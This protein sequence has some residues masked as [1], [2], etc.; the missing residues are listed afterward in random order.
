MLK[1]KYSKYMVIAIVALVAIIVWRLSSSY[2]SVN[3]GYTGKNI[4][5]GD[6]W[7]VNITKVGNIEKN[8]DS[9]DYDFGI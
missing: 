9:I 6:S 7:G 2:A 1:N 4:I 8:G 3:Q 5:S